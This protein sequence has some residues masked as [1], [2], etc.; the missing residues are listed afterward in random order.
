MI[1]GYADWLAGQGYGENTCNTQIAH[2]RQIQKYYDNLDN[3]I[4]NGGLPGLISEFTY[5][6]EDERAEKE[7][8]TKV[9]FSGRTYT[10]LQSLKGAIR[11]YARFLSEEAEGNINGVEASGELE[12]GQASGQQKQKFAL[13]R[14]M[15]MALRRDISA[16]DPELRIVD[17]GI[18]RSVDTGFIDILCEDGTGCAVVV[19]LKAGK[20]DARVI[21][22]ILGYM[23]DLL[24]EED[25]D[26]VRGII[27]AHSF[28]ARTKAAAK[29]I[30]NLELVKYEINFSFE[31]AP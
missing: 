27:V 28:D 10:R 1:K 31:A 26:G 22:Q 7:N 20:T 16:L 2:I 8:P 18:E 30:P 13:E 11:R 14:D 12:V 15:Q 23:G 25:S 29:A 24:T 5:T 6:K 4:S 3:L 21:G 19:E 9:E 17:D